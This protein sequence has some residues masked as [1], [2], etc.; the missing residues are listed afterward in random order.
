MSQL[1]SKAWPSRAGFVSARV[2]ENAA[3]RLDLRFEDIGEQALKNIARRVPAAG[4][5]STRATSGPALPEKPFDRGAAFRQYERRSGAGI[6]HRR[7]GDKI[8]TAL[9]RIRW[10]F[11][12]ARNSSFSYKGQALDVKQVGQQLGVR[13]VLAG[14]VR[15]AAAGCGSPGS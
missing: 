4:S 7:H 11:V 6:F 9:S 13:Y 15:K 2:Q 1:A 8:I 14:A 5:V 12:L 3:G 10:L